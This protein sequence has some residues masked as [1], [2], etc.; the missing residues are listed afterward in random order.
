V[1]EIRDRSL[2]KTLR[3]AFTIRSTDN[4]IYWTS[5][6]LLASPLRYTPANLIRVWW[7][8]FVNAVVQ[9]QVARERPAD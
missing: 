9:V 1:R 5:F 3:G 2:L 7:R 6:V 4:P 8:Y